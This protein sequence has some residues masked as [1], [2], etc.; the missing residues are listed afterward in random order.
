MGTVEIY[1]RVLHDDIGSFVARTGKL[2]NYVRA[3]VIANHFPETE[4]PYPRNQR[5]CL[6][7]TVYAN[8]SGFLMALT[9]ALKRKLP[10]QYKGALKFQI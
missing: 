5:K 2:T 3:V 7:L 4:K 1:V 9:A 10:L 6:L 8:I